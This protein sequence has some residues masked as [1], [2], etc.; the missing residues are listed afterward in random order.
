LDATPYNTS[1]QA[2]TVVAADN[3]GRPLTMAKASLF[4]Y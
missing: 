3:N 4:S 2:A 1:G